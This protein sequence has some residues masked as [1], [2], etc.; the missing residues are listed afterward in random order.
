MAGERSRWY[1]DFRVAGLTRRSRGESIG[2]LML[3]AGVSQQG[4]GAG[5]V[6]SEVDAETV[7]RT[8]RARVQGG[9]MIRKNGVQL[10]EQVRQGC[11]C[12]REL[13]AYA[14][15]MLKGARDAWT[16]RI[17]E[18][19]VGQEVN[20]RGEAVDLQGVVERMDDIGG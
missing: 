7:A 6:P 12:G 18:V 3:T 17:I 14:K 20:A 1:G 19:Q 11:R 8:L 2:I 16:L 15:K 4:R 13:L 10:R 9:V 5:P